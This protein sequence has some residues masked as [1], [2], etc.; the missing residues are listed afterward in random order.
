MSNILVI[1]AGSTS[2]KYKVFDAEEKQ[3][4]EGELAEIKDYDKALKQLLRRI[5][6]LGEIK[7]VGHRVV[8]G[9]DKFVQPILINEEVLAELEK[10]NYLAPLHNPYNLAGIRAAV[11]FLP[12]V[13]HMAVF[14]T[15]FYSTLPEEARIYALPRK[16]FEE[17]KLYRY[18]FHGASH[19]FALVEAARILDKKVDKI[20]LISCHLGGGCSITAVKNGRAIDTSMGYTPLEGLVMM[21]RA[22]DLDP[23]AVI[24]LIRRLPGEISAAKVE[25]VYDLLNHD[26]GI[27]GLTE[28][29][30]DFKELLSQ[31][32]LGQKKAVGAFNLF[33]YRLIKYIGAY[34][35]ALEGRL[36]A[37]VFTGAIGA[38][39]PLTRNRV[40]KKLK[41]LGEVPF[42]AVKTNEELMIFRK[43]KQLIK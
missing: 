29:S 8:H 20:N 26:S 36:D 42:L 27:K 2:I 23:G 37:V 14:D 7:A 43:V 18:G 28:G 38:G 13:P 10:L 9:A 39:N 25:S 3:L 30:G 35:S 1:N 31:V 5:I 16:I 40:I 34:W 17:L 41:F 24:E 4:S 6:N 15:A 21:S 12:E 19:E 32:S 11:N 33:V 22:G